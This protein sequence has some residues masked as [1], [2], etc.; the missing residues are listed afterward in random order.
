M[1]E[2]HVDQGQLSGIHTGRAHIN[3]MHSSDS[4]GNE[5]QR[6]R[7]KHCRA[8]KNECGSTNISTWQSTSSISTFAAT[9]LSEAPTCPNLRRTIQEI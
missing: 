2:R 4:E 8:A 3:R 9:Q 6:S 7:E 1:V 5:G